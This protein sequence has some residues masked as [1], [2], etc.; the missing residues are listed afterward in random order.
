MKNQV[1]CSTYL[2]PLTSYYVRKLLRQYGQELQSVLVEGAGQVADWQTDLNAVLESLYIEEEEINCS[3]RELETLIQQHQFLAAQGD[4]YS[5]QM[6]NIEQQVF[7][8][9][10]LKWI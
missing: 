1:V 8:L 7:W 9:L 3:A 10:G 4:L 6:E 5:T 2:A